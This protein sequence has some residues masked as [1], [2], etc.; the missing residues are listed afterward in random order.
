ME[1]AVETAEG[2]QGL[3]LGSKGARKLGAS[4]KRRQ[5]SKLLW[6]PGLGEELLEPMPAFLSA[7]E[8]NRET[9]SGWSRSSVGISMSPRRWQFHSGL[10]V[11][12]HHGVA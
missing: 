12:C 11:R 7:G 9:V 5:R 2:S 10:M 1:T 4:L 6:G 3:G 8:I